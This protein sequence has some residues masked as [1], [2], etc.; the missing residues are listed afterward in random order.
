ML[1][2]E[3]RQT[4]DAICNVLSPANN[5]TNYRKRLNEASS[6][7]IPFL[8]IH[9]GDLVYLDEARRKELSRGDGTAASKRAQQV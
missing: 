3:T 7:C 6:P 1:P 9:L 2:K 5:A 8:G 4:F